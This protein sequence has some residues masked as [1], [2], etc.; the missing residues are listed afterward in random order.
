[1]H[2]LAYNAVVMQ[3]Q[4]KHRALEVF[5]LGFAGISD[6][7]WEMSHSASCANIHLWLMAKYN[8]TIVASLVISCLVQGCL[9]RQHAL[10]DTQKVYHR[11]DRHG[12][13]GYSRQNGAISDSN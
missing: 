8:L 7:S 11:E 6:S 5:G 13:C 10:N 1:M 9:Q 12:E 2:V 4:V 3:P